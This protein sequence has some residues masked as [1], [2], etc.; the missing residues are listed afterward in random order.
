[1]NDTP[2]RSP[3]DTPLIA[4]EINI[5]IFVNGEMRLVCFASFMALAPL[6][7]SSSRTTSNTDA[8]KDADDWNRFL[9]S[10]TNTARSSNRNKSKIIFLEKGEEIIAQNN[11]SNRRRN[12]GPRRI[13]K[14]RSSLTVPLRE[15]NGGTLDGGMKQALI[16]SSRQYYG[17]RRMANKKTSTDF[18]YSYSD[19][20]ST[21]KISEP[22]YSPTLSPTLA[23]PSNPEET[24]TLRAEGLTDIISGIVVDPDTLFDP[25]SAQSRALQWLIYD[26]GLRLCLSDASAA[27]I[28]QRYIM[29]VFYYI[30]GGD[31]DWKKQNSYLSSTDECLWGGSICDGGETGF[32]EKISLDEN[33]LLGPFPDEF[34]LLS[35][36]ITL[37]LDSNQLSG[38]ISEDISKLPLL[39]VVDLDK[40]NLSGTIPNSLFNVTSLRVL[41]MNNNNI[42]GTLSSDIGNLVNMEFIQLHQNRFTG[43]IPASLSKLSLLDTITL[44]GNKFTGSVP[45]LLCDLGL[46]RLTSDC[47]RNDLKVQCDCCTNCL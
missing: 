41:D 10:D 5:D 35:K 39:E 12:L 13:R 29:V 25:D 1:L 40:N 30:T 22:T 14:G 15:D 42:G 21:E 18:S 27:K 8:A 26:D 24:A 19:K 28:I 23:C 9:W 37:D 32:I 17:R 6:F 7:A 2:S 46:N 34:Y 45:Q 4:I 43:S 47:L 31:T 16:E 20:P 44:H 11:L 38:T 3:L 33:N 36:L